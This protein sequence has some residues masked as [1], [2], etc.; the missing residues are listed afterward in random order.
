[1]T[2][3]EAVLVGQSIWNYIAEEYGVANISNI[4]NL[5]RIIRN[6]RNAIGS[7]LSIRYKT[8]LK[9]WENYYT[10]TGSEALQATDEPVYDFRLRKRNKKGFRF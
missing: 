9:R 1:M 6:E 7:S 8:F 10:Q 2:G 3:D 5:A 4:L